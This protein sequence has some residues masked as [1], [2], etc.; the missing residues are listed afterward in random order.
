MK[1]HKDIKNLLYILEELGIW[2]Y[3][4]KSFTS[5]KYYII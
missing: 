4:L 5:I 1:K 3:I 2:I